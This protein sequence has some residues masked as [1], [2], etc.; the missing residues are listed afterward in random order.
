M[1]K[2]DQHSEDRFRLNMS[3]ITGMVQHL[4]SSD[5][6]KP[7][8]LFGY[9]EGVR[10][11]ILRSIVVFLHATFEVVL[12][13]HLPRPNRSLSF[14]SS[15]DLD[16]ALR[17]S[18]IDAI[19]FRDLY[20]PLT[21]MAKRRKRIVHEADWSDHTS[22][23]W[24]IVDDWQLIM[25]LLAVPAFYYRLSLSINPV[26]SV[27]QA[28][29]DGLRS[30]MRDHVAFGKQLVALPEIPRELRLQALQESVTTLKRVIATLQVSADAFVVTKGLPLR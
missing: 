14:Y 17:L 20:P 10:A 7:I 12:R 19:P 9:S 3:R 28:R 15:S 13:G 5:S 24:G 29:Y 2:V 8:Q 25:W 27:D 1:G 16:K 4:S 6:L 23:Q 30:A 22:P 21:E 11:D 18:K 26:A